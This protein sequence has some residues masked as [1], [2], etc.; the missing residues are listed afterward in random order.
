MKVSWDAGDE[1]GLVSG[2]E[3]LDVMLPAQMSPRLLE[4]LPPLLSKLLCLA[5]TFKWP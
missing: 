5:N 4:L 3:Y 1:L 2:V